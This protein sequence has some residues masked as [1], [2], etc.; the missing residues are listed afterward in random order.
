MTLEELDPLR[1]IAFVSFQSGSLKITTG[2]LNEVFFKAVTPA[3]LYCGFNSY[4]EGPG[5]LLSNFR[6]FSKLS[7]CN[8]P[9][10]LCY[11]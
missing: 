6:E 11:L 5:S 9:A 2:H 4:S 8:Q 7:F 10:L 3:S 1:Q